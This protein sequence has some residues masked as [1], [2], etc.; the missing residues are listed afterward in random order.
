MSIIN[1]GPQITFIPGVRY[2]NL[3]TSYKGIRGIQNRL[4]YLEY[5]NYDTTVTQD[6]GYWLPNLSLRIKPFSWFDIRLSY[7]KTLSYPDFIAIIPRIDIVPQ[8]VL[9]GIISNWFPNVQQI[10]TF[11]FP[12]II[13]QSDYLPVA[14]S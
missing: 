2:Q 8:A 11:I 9:H 5:V 7:T 13:I 6:H 3:R 14:D 4:S 1:L 10:M 12:S